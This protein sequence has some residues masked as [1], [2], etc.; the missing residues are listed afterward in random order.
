MPSARRI[1]GQ[2]VDKDS[3]NFSKELLS[4]ATQFG[5]PQ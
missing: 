3:N 2:E 1:Y 5:S 4:S